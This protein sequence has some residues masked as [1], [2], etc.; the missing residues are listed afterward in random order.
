M[1]ADNEHVL[2]LGR[3]R[4]D[5][6][7]LVLANFDEYPQFVQDD[8]PHHTGIIGTA[9]NLLAEHI[10]LNISGGRLYLEPYETLWLTGE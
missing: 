4:Q 6:N 7:L 5:G 9:R 1:W 8:L 10:P 2:A 3:R